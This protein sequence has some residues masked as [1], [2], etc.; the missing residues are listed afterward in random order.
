M[1]IFEDDIAEGTE[2]LTVQLLAPPG[3]TGVAFHR[4]SAEISIIDDDGNT[5][6]SLN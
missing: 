6:N 3:E 1:E 5:I 2:Q 4:N